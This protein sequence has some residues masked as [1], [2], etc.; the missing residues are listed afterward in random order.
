MKRYNIYTPAVIILLAF[1]GYA[2]S[3]SEGKNHIKDNASVKAIAVKTAQVQVRSISIPIQ[4]IG[5]V[6]SRMES[7]L[8]FK[9]NGIIKKIYVRN[10]E[11]VKKGQLLAELDLIEIKA[12]QQKAQAAYD[13][14]ARDLARIKNL[15][16]E[17][18]VTL[19]TLQNAQTAFDIAQSDLEILNFNVTHSRIMAPADGV[20]LQKV[21]ETGEVVSAGQ[22][23][24]Q[25]GSTD[26][27][28]IIN[29]GLVD[30]EIVR[31][32]LGD[33]VKIS[34]DAYPGQKFNGFINKI[35]SAPDQL[36]NTY[37]IEIS[38]KQVP[39]NLRKGF[40]AK[41]TVI[42]S[43][44]QNYTLIP[45]EA[46]AEA[47]EERALIYTVQN[48]KAKK[49]HVKINSIIEDKVLVTG[50]L[51]EKDMVITEGV[52]EVNEQSTLLIK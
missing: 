4:A 22:S 11:K 6:S 37:D 50:D 19:E 17:R 45:I 51:S 7:S 24:F 5:T 2:C 32:N 41:V 35:G 13:K 43:G 21:R 36:T 29:S 28:W 46:I 10:G 42:P 3:T 20:I 9:N 52:T 39:S 47:E 16:Q 38:L 34:F 27:N 48:N 8:S 31:V 49:Q 14:T 33:Q 44:S 18:V 1:I 15:H 23:V 26:E 25:F 40:V 30:K 12:S